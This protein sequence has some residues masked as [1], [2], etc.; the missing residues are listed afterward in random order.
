M[1]VALLNPTPIDHYSPCIR[2]L[3]AYLKH[4]G[5]EVRMIFLPCDNYSTR[6]DPGYIKQMKQPLVDDLVEKLAGFDLV[7]VS[8]LSSMFDVAV[9]ATRAIQKAYPEMPIAWGG[10]HPST[11]PQ[12]CARTQR[13][14]SPGR[15][16]SMIA[17]GAFSAFST[18]MAFSV[19]KGAY[20]AIE[21]IPALTIIFMSPFGLMEIAAYSI[22]MSRSYILLHK[23]IK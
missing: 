20:P 22:A 8:F 23:I 12:Q 3:S 19:L 21:N 14:P 5:H 10:F 11:M 4:H 13:L 15:A 16:C 17:W 6:F 1:K 9:Q 18:G 2:S 7:G